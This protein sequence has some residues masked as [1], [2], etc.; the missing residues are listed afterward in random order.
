M[1]SLR[2]QTV[3]STALKLMLNVNFAQVGKKEDLEFWKNN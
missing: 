2:T 3:F 1:L